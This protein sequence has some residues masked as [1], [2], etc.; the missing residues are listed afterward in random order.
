[1]TETK[2]NLLPLYLSEDEEDNEL[3]AHVNNSPVKA[4][5]ARITISNETRTRA[6][7]DDR[8]YPTLRR[9]HFYLVFTRIK[10]FETPRPTEDE[11]ERL[12][13]EKIETIIS[14]GKKFIFRPRR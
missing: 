13:Q 3:F 7:K 12:V 4:I 10:K 8:I 1:M 2:G 6:E 11:I 9:R 14:P 5:R